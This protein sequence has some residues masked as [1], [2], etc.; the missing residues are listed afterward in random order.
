MMEIRVPTVED[1]EAIL[2]DVRFADLAEWYAGTGALMPQA[3]D[4]AIRGSDLV[5]TLV[6]DGTPLLLWGSDE[7]GRLWMFATN[8]AVTRALP[9]HR[10]M[11]PHLAELLGRYGS[12]FCFADCRNAVHLRW[13]RWMG[14]EELATISLPPFDLPFTAFT[15]D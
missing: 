12:V 3:V 8:Q 4:A 1:V 7:D 10:F 2:R 5:L 6:E 14:F 13:L 11:M 9:I 15:K